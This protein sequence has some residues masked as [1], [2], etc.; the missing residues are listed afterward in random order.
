MTEGNR[1]LRQTSYGI[2]SSQEAALRT[3]L[4]IMHEQ[5]L[6]F[7]Q[8]KIKF[9]FNLSSTSSTACTYDTSQR[10][11]T[12]GWWRRESSSLTSAGR[13]C[14]AA[15]AGPG[16]SY[17]EVKINSPDGPVCLSADDGLLHTFRLCTQVPCLLPPLLSFPLHPS[18]SFR[19]LCFTAFIPRCPLSCRA[20]SVSRCF[21]LALFFWSAG[22]FV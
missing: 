17:T 4:A 10:T 19:S 12:H 21:P 15:A 5:W 14:H 6:S 11:L 8:D 13:C 3:C 1:K 22:M 2:N 16:S 18:P 9:I 20:V 7:V